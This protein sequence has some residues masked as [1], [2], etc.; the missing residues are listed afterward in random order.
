MTIGLAVLIISILYFVDKHNRWRQLVKL[1]AGA[2]ILTALGLGGVFVYGQ[3]SDWQEARAADKREKAYA[4]QHKLDVNACLARYKAFGG[5]WT[6]SPDVWCENHP[7]AIPELTAPLPPGFTPLD[8]TQPMQS[9]PSVP[10]PAQQAGAVASV[11]P[12]PNAKPAPKIMATIQFTADST[13]CS[14]VMYQDQWFENDRRVLANFSGGE[15]VEYIGVGGF[16]QKEAI[17][18]Y[19]GMRGYIDGHCLTIDDA[20]VDGR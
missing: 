18:R 19:H 6:P 17:I 1:V 3:I 8:P 4:A 12:A 10:A 13:S 16:E 7:D 14:P 15:R 20:R 5:V 2:A 11:P 9:K